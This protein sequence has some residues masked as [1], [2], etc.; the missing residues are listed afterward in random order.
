[1]KN[2]FNFKF[3]Y[4]ALFALFIIFSSCTAR[5]NAR[6]IQ[7]GSGN[8]QI[9]AGLE[10]NMI[11]LLRSFRGLSSGGQSNPALD[12]ASINRSLQ[13]SPGVSSS[14]LRNT[15][16]EKIE[17]IVGISRFGDLLNA[18]ANR[19][20]SYQASS[21]AVSGRLAINLNRNIAPRVLEQISPDLVDYLSALMAPAATGEILSKGEYLSLVESVYGKALAGEIS[22]SRI[23]AV[24]ALPGPVKSVKG[25]TYLGPEARFDVP[26]ID[27]L[28]LERPLDYEITW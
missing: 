28:V 6:L 19:F 4:I 23:T 10:P 18:G 13:A 5:L 27:L 1:M 21:G 15:G 16:Q 14:S 3:A 22:A 26:V 8:I 17:G 24:I 25:G 20:I 12:A 7:D 2:L 9:Q 11:A